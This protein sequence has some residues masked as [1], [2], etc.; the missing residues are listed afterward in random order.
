MIFLTE[1]EIEV[2]KLIAE[3]RNNDFIAERLY[4]S[5][6]AIRSRIKKL[7]IKYGIRGDRYDKRLKLALLGKELTNNKK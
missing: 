4:R 3:G 1:K 2:L 6:D 7:Y 5:K